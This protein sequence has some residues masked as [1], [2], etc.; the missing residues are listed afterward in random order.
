VTSLSPSMSALSRVSVGG[1]LAHPQT[2]GQ[3]GQVFSNSL[4]QPECVG[5]AVFASL[6]G[7]GE[8]NPLSPW[9]S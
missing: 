5:E 7:G 1:A 8:I 4:T 9:S 3:L 6:F 2:R